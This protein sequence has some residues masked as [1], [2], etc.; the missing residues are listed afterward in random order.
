MRIIES[1]LI[2]NRGEIARRII[3]ACQKMGIRSVA[4]FSDADAN[5]LFVQEADEAIALG[6]N[7]PADT[8]LNFEK[9]LN[10][11]KATEATA[12]HPGYGFLAENAAFATACRESGIIF[13]G[14]K[15]DSIEQMGSKSLA[16]SLME[17]HDVPVIPGYKGDDQ[18]LERFTTEAES[19]GYPVLLKAVAGGG[20]K[21]M[22]IVEQPSQMQSA[23]EMAKSEAKNAFGDD[24]MMLEK[25]FERARHIEFQIFGDEHGNAIHLHERECSLQRRHQK[26]LEESPSP[27]L[28]ASVKEQMASSAINAAKA[29]NYVNA[30]T[31]EFILTEDGQYYFLEVNTRLQVEHPVTEMITGLDLVEW[32]IRVAQG[33]VLPITN[34]DDIPQKGYAVELRLYA[35][36]SMKGFL[37]AT[38]TVLK[39]SE[40]NMEGVRYESAVQ[41]GDDV[42]VFYDPMIAK[43]V[44]WAENRDAAFRKMHFVLGKTDCLG[45]T[46]NQD[47]L[48]YLFEQENIQKGVYHTRL[49]DETD[50]LLKYQQEQSA[51]QIEPLI[52]LSLFRW[53]Q[54]NQKKHV[55]GNLPSAWRNNFYQPQFD[56][57]Q[58]GENEVQ[59]NYKVVKTG[60]EISVNDQ[61]YKA[62]V[63]STDEQSI[64]IQLNDAVKT[65]TIAGSGT[66][67]VKESNKAKVTET[68]LLE[69]LPLPEK[70]E[71]KGG[72]TAPMPG[73]IIKVLVEKGNKVSK[74]QAL[75]ILTSM[76]MENTITANADGSIVD[77]FIRTNDQVEAGTLLLKIEED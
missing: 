11:A 46:T 75:L 49:F 3:R 16:K 48:Q 44:V 4:I 9:V 56:K 38:G 61:N 18:S 6:G 21:G 71:I 8:Y 5:A 70:E 10:A 1:I 25:Y 30:G 32:Q 66:Y 24:A 23:Y 33:E 40:V 7:A 63:L 20:G 2:A 73:E 55:L 37:P 13:I 52:A 34:Q 72:Y 45:L 64:R 69:R 26:I 29:L 76:K 43:L 67:Y 59:V 58:V 53:N 77:I 60:F 12:I 27:V 54:R 74:G 42:S 65:Y 36:D 28:S 14:P 22:R 19:I 50:I 15:A 39:W 68:T 35:E 31:V 41:T 51:A 62:S 17:A 47:F 57:Y